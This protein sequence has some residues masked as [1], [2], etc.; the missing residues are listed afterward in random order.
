MVFQ[1]GE[2]HGK[3][4]VVMTQKTKNRGLLLAVDV[5]DHALE[6]VRYVS[7][8]GPFQ[9]KEVVV[10]TVHGKIPE[11]YWDLEKD[12]PLGWRIKNVRAWERE[13]EKRTHEYMDRARKILW[14]AGF[15]KDAVKIKIHKR[16]KGLAR[17]IIKEAQSGYS[18]VV[19]GRKGMS[20][21]KGLVLGSVTAKLLEKITFIPLIVVGRTPH[22]GTVL[23]AMDGSEGAMRAVDFV[24]KMLGGF[25]F[26]VGL[27]HVIRGDKKA[28]IQEIEKQMSRVFN[29]ASG[30]LLNSGFELNQISTKM[31]TGVHSRAETIVEEAGK[32]GYGTIV[33]GRRGLS[34]VKEFLIGGVSNKVIQLAKKQAVWVVS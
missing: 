10:F 22:P 7:K 3:A 27:I 4:D 11:Y 9:D 19:V 18:C 13:Y 28:Y 23:L 32:G 34:K 17:D 12:P 2:E 33:V 31:I 1:I 14:R 15:P 6:A 16:E 29:E 25:D 8:T 26:E 30:R 21:V 5:S 20:E 24:G